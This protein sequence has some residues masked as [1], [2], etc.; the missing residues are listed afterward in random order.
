MLTKRNRTYLQYIAYALQL[1]FQVEKNVIKRAIQYI[2]DRTESLM[3]T[4]LVEKVYIRTHQ[5]L[6]QSIC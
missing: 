1:Y 3:T 6:V 4:F 5:K 2:K